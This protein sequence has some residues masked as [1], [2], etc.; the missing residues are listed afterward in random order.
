[1]T[2]SAKVAEF[3][4]LLTNKFEALNSAPSDDIDTYCDSITSSITEA[5][6]KT[7][8]KDKAQRHGKLSLVTKQLREKRRQMKR[9]GTDIH[10]IEYTEICKAI[11]S[12][13]SEDINNYNEE[14]LIKSLEDNKGIKTIKRKQCLGRSNIISLKEENG[15]H[16]N[17]RD[18]MIK[19]CEEFYT[20]LYSTKLPQGQPSVQIHN[21][22]STPPPPILPTEVS[23]AI[24]RLK[25]NKA[26]GNDNITADVLKDGGEPI[27]Q[28]F[29]NMFNRCLREGKLPNSWKDASVIIIHKK[30]DTADIK[31]YR[32]ISLLPITYKVFSQVILRR[33]LRTLDQH[34]PREQ[35]GFRSGFST[36]DHIQV[37]SQLQEKADEYNIP[38]CFAFVDYE[39]AFDSI[40]FN[41]LFESLEN[42]GVEAAYITLLRDLY[43]GATSTLKLHRDSDKIKLQR[44]VRQGDNISPKLFTA[45][46]QD[47]IINKINWEDKGINID[48]EHLS[49]LI[50]ADYIVLVAKSPEELESMLTDI[51]LASKPVGLSMNLSKTKVMLNESATTSTVAVDG[52]TIEKV[53][54]YVYLGKTVTQAGDLLPEIKRRI[55]LGWAAFSKVA[56]IMKSRKASMN[57]KR[58]VHNEYVL[59]V[60]V[61]GS[62]TWALKKAHMELLS[63]AQRKMERIMLGIT[64]RDH[65][66]NTWIRHQTGVNDI[67]DVIKKG[68]HGWAGHIARFKDNRW[69]KRVTEWTPRE[70][71]RRQGRPKTRWRDSLIHHLGPSWPRIARDR[72]L[73]RQFREGFLLTE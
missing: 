6:L 58:K 41:P 42:Q 20:N 59:P 3:Q 25:R 66:R 29:T 5:A 73:W 57:V 28:M 70:W 72:R 46:L 44:G 16:I 40:E 64:L 7:A 23:A 45:C 68:I 48:G 33:M 69:T 60:M 15:T 62:E 10:H 55:A 61:Y 21:T 9:N 1:M 2:L 12:R 35:A 39:K 51:Q 11:R 67:I 24:K 63:V 49:H 32:P 53:D 50:F 8:G 18:R 34:R 43:N 37:I 14:Q 30:G 22:R 26:P 56:N 54:R 36:I 4:L 38:L 65:K 17:D 31:N 71:K 13:M 19:R 27:V 47:A 52:N